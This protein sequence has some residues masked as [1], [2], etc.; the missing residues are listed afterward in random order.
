MPR[1]TT[2]AIAAMNASMSTVAATE[3]S[4]R[5]QPPA[6]YMPSRISNGGSATAINATSGP[7]S[8]SENA[9][10]TEARSSGWPNFKAPAMMKSAASAMRATRGTI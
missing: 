1:A 8:P 10:I 9:E 7:G 4:G 2:D 5:N 6:R 3:V